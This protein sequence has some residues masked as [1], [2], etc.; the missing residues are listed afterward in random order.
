MTI[1]VV[2]TGCKKEFSSFVNNPNG[3]TQVPPS[4][5][6]RS[7]LTDMY[8][9]SNDRSYAPFS[10]AERECQFTCSNY[11][12]YDNNL[13]WTGSATWDYST[14]Y[15]VVAMESQAARVA[16][17]TQTPYHA[18]GKFFRAWFYVDMTMKVGDI[19][20]SQALKG[21]GNI[22]PKYDAQKQVFLTSLN[23]LDSANTQ[24]AGFIANGFNEFSGDIYHTEGMGNL[25]PRQALIQWQ[26]IVNTFRLRVL[27]DLSVKSGDADLNVPAQF[28]NIYNNPAKYP[29][30]TGLSDNLQ[31]VYNNTTNYYPNSP[32]N[33]GNDALRYNMGATYLNTLSSLNDIRAE[34]VAEPARGLGLADTA[35]GSFKGAPSGED[36]GTMSSQ[37]Q[38]GVISLIGRHR[39]WETYTGE[40]CMIVS[41]P[42]MCFNIAEAM[43]RGWVSGSAEQWYINGIKASQSFYGVVDGANTVTFQAPGGS[44]GTD[45]SYT[46]HFNFANYYA[47]P[48]VKYSSTAATALTQIQTQKYLAFFRNSGLQAYFEWRRTG[49]PTMSTGVGISVSTNI[50]LRFQYPLAEKSDNTANYTASVTSQFGSAGDDIFQTLWL[51]KP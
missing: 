12:Y 19:P 43:N 37:I 1:L 24:L 17:T 18:L 29:L 25:S 44:L 51:L 5:I 35:Y 34:I 10:Q 2:F 41:Y 36:L 40:P 26:K 45:I 13:F 28:A 39:Y 22:T 50:P 31:Y 14:L 6:L 7:I 30:M 4:L 16:G 47:Q 46:K 15:N 20:V 9:A 38:T 21:T 33:F 8:S 3:D 48:A 27:M 49:V 23:L 32:S 11:T 42:E